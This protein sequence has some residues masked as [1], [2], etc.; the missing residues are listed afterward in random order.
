MQQCVAEPVRQ[1]GRSDRKGLVVT[2]QTSEHRSQRGLIIGQRLV[3]KSLP[4]WI[5][6]TTVMLAFADVEPDEHP[7]WLQIVR[8]RQHRPLAW[9]AGR[10]GYPRRQ[11]R[12]EQASTEGPRSLSAVTGI[13]RYRRK[14]PQI[15]NDRG[16]QPY[17]H[18]E[19]REEGIGVSDIRRCSDSQTATPQG[20]V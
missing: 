4:G 1:P 13:R 10:P 19:V 3:I 18:S 7:V 16:H 11:P 5:E 20:H 15:I 9:T 12:Y 17:R 6:C 2:G 8:S 14:H